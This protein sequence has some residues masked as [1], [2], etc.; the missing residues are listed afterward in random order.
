MTQTIPVLDLAP[1]RANEPGALE[2]L[3][4]EL[5]HAFT[6]VGFYFLRGHG[7]PQSLL[8]ATFAEA[9][10]FHAQPL[11]AKSAMK[12]DEHNIGY[13]PMRGATARY[14]LVGDTPVLPNVNEAVFFKRELPA[15]HVDVLAKARFRGRNRWPALSAAMPAAMSSPTGRTLAPGLRPA[16]AMILSPSARTSSCMNTVSAP[17]GI[18]APVKIR[19]A[20]PGATVAPAE[21][22]AWTRP[23]TGNVRS[24]CWGRSRLETA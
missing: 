19:I 21:L 11:E 13:M 1:L 16:G 17:S 10:R 12:I 6:E 9:A 14:N 5:R 8:D 24:P 23:T 3:G 7:V 15:D 2:K 18:G 4:A 22:P 20:C